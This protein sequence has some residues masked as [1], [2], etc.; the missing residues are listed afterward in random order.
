MDTRYYLQV[1]DV[2]QDEEYNPHCHVMGLLFLHQRQGRILR[3]RR[4]VPIGT[5]LASITN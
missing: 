1:L 5:A 3:I 2:A 4:P